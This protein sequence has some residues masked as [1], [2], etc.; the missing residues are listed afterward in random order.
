MAMRQTE[1]CSIW[2]W[3][4]G[5]LITHRLRVASGVNSQGAVSSAARKPASSNWKASNFLGNA[6]AVTPSASEIFSPGRVEKND[7][8]CAC[9][10]FARKRQR[11]SESEFFMNM[12]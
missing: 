7:V 1:N 2:P 10:A 9:N 3:P 5:M 12:R 11:R 6:L 4:I 8:F